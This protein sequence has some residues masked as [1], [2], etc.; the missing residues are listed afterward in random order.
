LNREDGRVE[1]WTA[2][3]PSRPPSSNRTGGFPASGSHGLFRQPHARARAR[4]AA[5]LASASGRQGVIPLVAGVAARKSVC[6]P[7]CLGV[8]PPGPLRSAGVT[9][10]QRY[11]GPIRLL[12]GPSGGY[13]FPPASGL[14]PGPRGLSVPD[15]FCR[16]APS[17]T[18]PG[19]P[20]ALGPVVH[21]RHWASSSS[22]A[23]PL[24]I[25]VTRLNGFALA[26]A[27]AFAGWTA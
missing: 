3:L 6:R 22:T 23:W 8:R 25:G 21:R 1:D 9:P 19:S 13:V 10:R 15:P 2:K 20:A 12:A 17:L 14:A 7:S 16:H 27:R 5:G 26:T 24:P 4:L 18:T 11:Y